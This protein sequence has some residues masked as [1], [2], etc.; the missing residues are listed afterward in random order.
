MLKFSA[1]INKLHL[2]GNRYFYVTLILSFLAVLTAVPVVNMS[3]F[4]FLNNLSSVTGENVWIFFTF[5]S[6]GLVSFVILT[7]F[8]R[9]KPKIIFAV[10]I[11]AIISTI[12]NQI[13]K[14]SFHVL[15][16]TRVLDRNSMI[17]IGPDWGQYSFPS[18]H[19][20]M[21]FVLAS[22]ISE[23]GKRPLKII[24][25]F[26]ASIIA[27]SRAVV[28]VHWPF[29]IT[30]GAA[31]GWISG[32]LGYCI[33]GKILWGTG[34]KAAIFYGFLLAVCCI[35]LFLWDYSGFDGIMLF[36]KTVALVFFAVCLVEVF[37]LMKRSPKS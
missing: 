5:F 9:K 15:R 32:C 21:V 36:Q 33:A 37:Y 4:R 3:I 13:L 25:L 31:M 7:P 22:V 18:G 12:L 10:I 28:G 30:A 2:L 29:D 34:R 8:V 20:S 1:R 19:A 24:V 26:I 14:R 17:L 16:P 6:D 35:V 27:I 23:E 11:A